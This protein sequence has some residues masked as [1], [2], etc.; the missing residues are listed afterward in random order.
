M[1]S[2]FLLLDLSLNHFL[3]LDFF[4]IKISLYFSTANIPPPTFHTSLENFSVNFFSFFSE[5]ISQLIELLAFSQEIQLKQDFREYLRK[6]FLNGWKIRSWTRI[7]CVSDWLDFEPQVP[8]S[9]QLEY[10]CDSRRQTNETRPKSKFDDAR[11]QISLW[12]ISPRPGAM[13]RLAF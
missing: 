3:L 7:S 8:I 5:K 12:L 2:L 4:R 9:H 1:L 13:C 6:V 10:V 11:E